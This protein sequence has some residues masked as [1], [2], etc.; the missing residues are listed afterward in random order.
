MDEQGCRKFQSKKERDEERI[1]HMKKHREY[2]IEKYNDGLSIHRIWK[3]VCDKG[4]KVSEDSIKEILIEA[5]LEIK[6]A[7][8]YN[9]RYV[10]DDQSFGTYDKFSCY[11]AGLFAADGCVYHKSN[12]YYIILSLTDEETVKHFADYIGYTGGVKKLI[13]NT[14]CSITTVWE[15]RCINNNIFYNLQKNFNIV[16]NKTLV[17]VPPDK[18]P[19]DLKRYFILGYID[20]D[21]SITKTKSSTEREVYGINITGTK[22]MLDYIADYFKVSHLKRNKRHPERKVNNETLNIAGNN[23]VQR[24]LKDLYCDEDINKIC[25]QR[26]RNRY[27][28][29]KK[30]QEQ[31]ASV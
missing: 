25:I 4:W 24:L 18:I 13:K 2:I 26:K 11:W 14:N 22:E 8:Y 3:E 23:Q 17:Y 27:L 16:P 1:D 7:K 5:G 19:D 10:S 29:L 6:T 30:Q 20:G 9:K 12:S 31:K 15:V 21:G 28:E